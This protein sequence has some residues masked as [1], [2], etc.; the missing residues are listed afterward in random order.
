MK[1]PLALAAMIAAAPALA[2]ENPFGYLY[3][4]ETTP[5]GHW[6]Y[7]QWNTLRT[8]KA[9][10]SYSAFDLRNEVETGVTDRLSL[11]LYLNSSYLRTRG[12]YDPEDATAAMKD[13]SE[14]QVNGFSAEAVYRLLSPYKDAFGLA[15]YLE[16]EVAARSAE[17]GEDIPERAL[18]ARVILQ[19]DFLD[20]RLTTVLNL[21]AEPEWE[22]DHGAAKK[23]LWTEAA[24]GASYRVLPRLSAGLEILHRAQYPGMNTGHQGLYAVYLGPNLH[25]GG[26][27]FWLTLTALPQVT[28]WPRR[29]GVGADGAEVESRNLH[30]GEQER[31]SLRLKLGVPF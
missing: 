24:L 22:K 26:E 21:V 10:G 6:E 14:F 3:T 18:E 13:R 9:R 4:A 30:L 11:S 25:Y 15:L 1:I 2:G 28:G 27:K 7:E 8:G 12:T 16:P 5:A 29:L 20:D 17:N 19:K 31:F 23:E